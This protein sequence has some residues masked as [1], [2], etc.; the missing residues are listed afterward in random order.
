[1]VQLQIRSDRMN[2]LPIIQTAI[3]SQCKRIEIGLR[4][5]EQIIRQFEQKYQL[6]SRQFLEHYTAEDLAGGDIEYISWLGE[7]KLRQNIEEELQALQD[8]EYVT[9]GIPLESGKQDS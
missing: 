4:K 3:T 6:S 8:I 2:I 1:M 9:Q 5:T 7:L